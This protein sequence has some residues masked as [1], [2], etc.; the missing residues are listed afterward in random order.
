MK[1]ILKTLSYKLQL[2]DFTWSLPLAILGFFM[3]NYISVKIFNDPDLSIEWFSFAVESSLILMLFWAVVTMG[4]FFFMRK[5]FRYFNS[6]DAKEDFN[7]L[8]SWLKIFSYPLFCL[9]LLVVL[10]EI[11][12]VVA[13]Q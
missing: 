5:I 1:K 13:Q 2:F 9:V 10:L 7:K 3:W 6:K 12:K 11:F 4:A 8:P